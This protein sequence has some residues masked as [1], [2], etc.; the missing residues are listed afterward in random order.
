MLLN[1]VRNASIPY[2]EGH[3]R[4][5][6]AASRTLPI[7]ILRQ[8]TRRS[9]PDRTHTWSCPCAAHTCCHQHLNGCCE[10]EGNIH[11]IGRNSCERQGNRGQEGVAK[12]HYTAQYEP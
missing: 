7:S 9:M 11:K 12:V 10:E 5:A 2:S 6:Y 4:E 3:P 1:F 8:I